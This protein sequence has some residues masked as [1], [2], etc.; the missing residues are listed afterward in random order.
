VGTAKPGEHDCGSD[1]GGQ[2]AMTVTKVLA[3]VWL[4]LRG[5]QMNVLQLSTQATGSIGV[6]VQAVREQ[7]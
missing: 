4:W 7:D 1:A 2:T 3:E 6:L 5:V